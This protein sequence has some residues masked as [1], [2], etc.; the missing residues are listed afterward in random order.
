MGGGGGE[1]VRM[2]IGMRSR[3][4]GGGNRTSGGGAVALLA[5]LRK[6]CTRASHE[7]RTEARHHVHGEGEE[8][9]RRVYSSW[10]GSVM[11]VWVGIW[12]TFRVILTML[13]D[14]NGGGFV[15]LI[16]CT[17]LKDE[18]GAGAGRRYRVSRV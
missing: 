11:S 2:K 3:R 12:L 16:S 18:S 4:Y 5:S 8:G 13:G 9:T 10:G 7:P 6:C 1:W 17:V 15:G 14:R